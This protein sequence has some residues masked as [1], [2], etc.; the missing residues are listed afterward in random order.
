MLKSHCLQSNL[1]V[2]KKNM[3]NSHTQYNRPGADSGGTPARHVCEE[4]S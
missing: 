3:K 2:A 1:S 4:R